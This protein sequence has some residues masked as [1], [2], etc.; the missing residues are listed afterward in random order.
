MVPAPM[1]VG[2]TLCNYVLIEAISHNVSLIGSFQ[3]FRGDEFPFTPAPFNA[4]ASLIGGQGEDILEL[5]VTQLETDDELF[6]MQHR[7]LFP[8]RFKEVHVL[9]R[10]TNCIFPEVGAYLFTL[11]VDG[12]WMAQ[13]RVL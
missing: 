7:M 3:S 12:E 4:F 1:A 5:I 10:V 8:D 13:R 9:F 6:K 11:L 2:L